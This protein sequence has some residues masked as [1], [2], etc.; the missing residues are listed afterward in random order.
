MNRRSYPR[1]GLLFN[2]ITTYEMM[3][4]RVPSQR[5]EM[6][7]WDVFG[8]DSDEDDG[9]KST[10]TDEP[11]MVRPLFVHLLTEIGSVKEVLIGHHSGSQPLIHGQDGEQLGPEGPVRVKQSPSVLVVSS[12]EFTAATSA[13][14]SRLSEAHYD[15]V[16]THHDEGP[17]TLPTDHRVDCIVD[18]SMALHEVIQFICLSIIL[19]SLTHSLTHSPPVPSSLAHSLPH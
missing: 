16:I 10:G 18:L 6:S 12:P 1:I 7:G 11:A 8:D 2:L 17:H 9:A 5:P 3:V 14:H 4:S 13:L 19:I 15:R